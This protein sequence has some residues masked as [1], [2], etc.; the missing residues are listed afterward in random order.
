[1]VDVEE[2][3]ADFNAFM[4]SGCMSMP[5]FQALLSCQQIW[6]ESCSALGDSSLKILEASLTNP[7]SSG[8]CQTSERVTELSKDV[9][10]Q[11]VN[12]GRACITHLS[13]D[14]VYQTDS[15]TCIPRME[16]KGDMKPRVC[17]SN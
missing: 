11:E 1:M 12:D 13:E 14:V 7:P 9:L 15:V 2:Y 5:S 6:V 16:S 4:T 8:E 17:E 10:F 3:S